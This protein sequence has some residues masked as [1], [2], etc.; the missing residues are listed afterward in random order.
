VGIGE[1]LA[2]E[3]ISRAIAIGRPESV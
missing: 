3:F 1:A 2:A